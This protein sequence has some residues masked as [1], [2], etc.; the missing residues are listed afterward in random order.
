MSRPHLFV[1][2]DPVSPA[3][4]LNMIYNFSDKFKQ[5]YQI[6]Y[7]SIYDRTIYDK[8]EAEDCYRIMRPIV[9]FKN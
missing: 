7:H 4:I 5:V 1:I 2:D 3:G 8:I 6:H 9:I